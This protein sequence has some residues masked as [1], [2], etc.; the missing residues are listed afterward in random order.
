VVFSR[1]DPVHTGFGF[2]MS[3]RKNGGKHT[4]GAIGVH[5]KDPYLELN[6]LGFS[7]RNNTKQVWSWVQ[8]RTTD[9]WWI[10]RNSY[11]NFNFYSTWNYQDVNYGLGGNFNSY[12]EFTNYW[13]LGGGIEMQA[14][15]YS[16]VE[17]RG[18]GLWEWPVTPTMATWFSL[19]TDQRKKLSFNWNPGGGADRGGWWW[20]NYVGVQYRPRSNTEF[21]FG[22]NYTQ[23]RNNLRWV[24]NISDE[25]AWGEDVDSSLF[26]NL[27]RD[28]VFL[29]AS[30]SVLFNRDLSLQLSAEGLISALDYENYRY[31]QGGN[32]Y[33]PEQDDVD[34]DRNFASLNSTLLLR[35]EYRPGSTLYVVWTRARPETLDGLNNLAVGRDLKRLFSGDDYNTFLIKA[36]Y[37]VNM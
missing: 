8:Y 22:V 24:D 28:Q 1:V 37:W 33:G 6:N 32:T 16:D 26:A 14:E 11:N 2:D 7:S 27:N 30:A 35:W 5:V 31:Y 3:V 13:S 15:K 36:S 19:N 4:R 12:V 21:E 34:Y 25:D 17:T 18:N 10:V 29:H 20:A 23:N 9:D